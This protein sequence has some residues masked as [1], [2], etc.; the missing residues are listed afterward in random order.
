[1]AIFPEKSILLSIS[2]S[3]ATPV[4]WVFVTGSFLPY[5]IL[6]GAWLIQRIQN[7]VDAS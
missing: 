3:L 4:K 2:A 5:L 6:L 1:M 7:R